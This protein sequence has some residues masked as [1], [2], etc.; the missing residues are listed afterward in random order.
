[1]LALKLVF[2][3]SYYRLW[4]ITISSTATSDGPDENQYVFLFG[5]FIECVHWTLNGLFRTKAIKMKINSQSLKVPCLFFE[6]RPTLNCT[7]LI[8]TYLFSLSGAFCVNMSAASDVWGGAVG[9]GVQGA[10]FGP[11]HMGWWR[12]VPEKP[13]S[14]DR[15]HPSTSP[16]KKK[17]KCKK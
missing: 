10:P 11:Q 1:M 2:N 3:D 4:A 5:I 12:R 14:N 13:L 7:I 8:S 17:W 15:A 16:P 9:A 6:K